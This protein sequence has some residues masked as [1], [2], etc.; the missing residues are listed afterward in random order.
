MSYLMMGTCLLFLSGIIDFVCIWLVKS[1]ILP[2]N[3]AKKIATKNFVL[4]V[5][6]V[7]V[8]IFSWGRK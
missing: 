2:Y 5:I 6:A 4:G 3:K 8:I 7:L 1:G